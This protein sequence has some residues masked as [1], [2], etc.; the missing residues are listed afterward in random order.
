MKKQHL[1]IASSVI[2]LGL[3]FGIYQYFQAFETDN[4]SA[5][6]V[7]TPS[8]GH[9]WAEMECS[10]DTLCID[11]ENKR[12]GIGTNTPATALDVVGDV[13]VSQGIRLNTEGGGKPACDSSAR[14]TIWVVSSASGVSD[15]AYVCLKNSSNVY[16]WKAMSEITGPFACGD[17]VSFTYRG[18]NVTYGTVTSQAGE[19]FMDRNLGATQVATAYNDSAAY[20]DLFQ[21]GRSDDGH[22]VRTSG[23]TTTLSATDSPPATFIY[24][25]GSPY[26]WRT[27]QKD[28]LWQGV[29]GIN[30]PCPAGWRLPTSTE[31]QAE[32]TAGSW[33]SY[34]T[35]Y[36]SPLKLTASGARDYGDASLTS[37]GAYGGYWS[38]S[39]SGAGASRLNFG[40]GSANMNA[41]S[42]AYGF[43]VR[44]LRD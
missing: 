15:S 1:F 21:W 23:T 27:P 6:T 28:T 9:S 26:D 14:G 13:S 40:S 31:W 24:G 17:A 25:M 3:I 7:G 29:D 5:V 12:L 30:N 20:G 16:A 43:S 33:V 36:A 22:Q 10:A 32:I 42:R 11:A 41:N 38:S 19:C 35:A 34:N 18:S 44:C 8:P 39:V 37:V 4:V 2:F